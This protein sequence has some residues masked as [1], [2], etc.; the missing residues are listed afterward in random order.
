MTT[1]SRESYGG[2]KLLERTFGHAVYSGK[3]A[4]QQPNDAL[5]CVVALSIIVNSA[6]DHLKENSNQKTKDLSQ[7]ATTSVSSSAQSPLLRISMQ[8]RETIYPS[9]ILHGQDENL[10]ELLFARNLAVCCGFV[11]H[12]HEKFRT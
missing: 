10:A 6:L 2:T 8:P 12:V 3:L 1:R 5:R 7:T 9:Q 4:R 11:A